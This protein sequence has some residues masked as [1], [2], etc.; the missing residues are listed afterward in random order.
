MEIQRLI[1]RKVFQAMQVFYDGNKTL[2]VPVSGSGWKADKPLAQRSVP[3]SE[4]GAGGSWFNLGL[5]D[6]S[7]RIAQPALSWN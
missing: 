2:A 4:N 1:N 3:L 5:A 7:L 6:C